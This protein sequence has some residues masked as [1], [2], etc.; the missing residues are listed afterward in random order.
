MALHG[1][2][3]AELW[4]CRRFMMLLTRA[5]KTVLDPKRS[6]MLAPASCAEVCGD[7]FVCAHLVQ[8]AFKT[9]TPRLSP[10][11]ASWVVFAMCR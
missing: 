1:F 2:R 4:P 6:C 10:S 8:T 5:S 7:A 9:E 3:E 11:I